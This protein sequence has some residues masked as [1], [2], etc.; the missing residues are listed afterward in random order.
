MSQD[1]ITI[2]EPP[3]LKSRPDLSPNPVGIPLCGM[4][5]PGRD[6]IFVGRGFNPGNLGSL[7]LA[8]AVGMKFYLDRTANYGH[9]KIKATNARMK[10][11]SIRAFVAS[12]LLKDSDRFPF[13][14]RFFV[15]RPES[16][17]FIIFINYLIQVPD[18]F[19]VSIRS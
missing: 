11:K 1:G 13:F 12:L 10:K 18:E 3:L 8:N 15:S 9:T 17:S 7:I 6:V 4:S 5:A 16:Y 2:S 19:L 14:L